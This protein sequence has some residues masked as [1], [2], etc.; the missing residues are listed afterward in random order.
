[1][2]PMHKTDTGI[3]FSFSFSSPLN[4]PFNGQNSPY[5]LQCFGCATNNSLSICKHPPWGVFTQGETVMASRAFLEKKHNISGRGG[6]CRTVSRVSATN[7]FS[8]LTRQL[9]SL[10]LLYHQP[11]SKSAKR[12]RQLS[13]ANLACANFNGATEKG[14]E[15]IHSRFFL[16][17]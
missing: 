17:L 14:K 5:I 1:M 4:T 6:G 16:L 3:F 13:R 15:N 8:F 7:G 2:E 9:G 10:G 12:L 11:N